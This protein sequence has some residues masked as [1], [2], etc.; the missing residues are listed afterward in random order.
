MSEWKTP[1]TDWYGYTDGDGLYH[2]DRFNTDDFNRIKNNLVYLRNLAV[3]LYPQFT[4]SNMGEDKSKDQY[5]YAEEINTIENNLKVIAEKTF[6]PDIGESSLYVANGRLFDYQ[7]LNRIEGATLDM[8]NQ[9]TNQ[10]KGRR[11]LTFTLGAKQE[12]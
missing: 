3:S 2:G 12:V 4:L 9:L 10:Y 8:Y 11:M 7:E 1:K 6:A 5:F